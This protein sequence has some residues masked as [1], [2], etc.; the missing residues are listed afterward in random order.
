MSL[1]KTEIINRLLKENGNFPNNPFLPILIYKHAVELGEHDGPEKIESAFSQ[2]HWGSFWRNGIYDYHHYHSTAHEA[3]G[4]YQGKATVQ[5]GGPEGF[6]AEVEKGDV[7]LIP[8]GVAHKNLGESGGFKCVG[9]YPAGQEY[10]MKYG[11]QG[12]RPEVDATIKQVP[13]PEC[14]PVFGS[15]GGLIQFW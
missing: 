9:A 1:Y 7:V 13:Y 15:A 5:F 6:V 14:D 2:N 4:I 10:D 12:E 3:L 8:A 11:K